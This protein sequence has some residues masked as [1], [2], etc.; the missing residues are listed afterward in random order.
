M[1]HELSN[2]QMCSLVFSI[3]QVR[4]LSFDQPIKCSINFFAAQACLAPMPM[5]FPNPTYLTNFDA[6]ITLNTEKR[7]EQQAAAFDRH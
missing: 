6:L 5:I 3:F 7:G 1:E 4:S 2:M